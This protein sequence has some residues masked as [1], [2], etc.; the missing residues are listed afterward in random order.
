MKKL[1]FKAGILLFGL[2][3][4]TLACSKEN[5]NILENSSSTA[6][7]TSDQLSKAKTQFID[8]MKTSEYTIYSDALKAFVDKMNGNAIL[9]PT[10]DKYMDWIAQNLSKTKFTS[11]E[12][13]SLMIDDL[14]AKN[15]ILETKNAQLFAYIS[16]A[17]SSQFLEIV[18]PSLGKLPTV[19]ALNS[20][21]NDCINDCEF[22][23]NGNEYAYS[24][25]YGTNNHF[26][27]Q[28]YYWER[29]K[30]ICDSLSGCVGGC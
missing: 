12:E 14:L 5:V 11:T 6:K 15:S 27:A 26:F 9:F 3:L 23:L 28:Q 4:L 20:C 24:L 18:Q 7:V 8:M 22:A 2:S 19:T 30:S 29:Y 1:F 17:D 21:V 13:F 25:D 16:E 10:K